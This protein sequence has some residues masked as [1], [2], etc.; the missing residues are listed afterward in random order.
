MQTVLNE[1]QNILK[2]VQSLPE[3][4]SIEEAMER[5]FLLYKIEKGCSQADCGKTFS[6]IEAQKQMERWLK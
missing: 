2:T 1:K 3:N 6:H 4:T 5:L